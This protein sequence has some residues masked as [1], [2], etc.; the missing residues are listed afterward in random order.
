HGSGEAN[1]LDLRH[2]AEF[3]GGQALVLSPVL[4]L[5]LIYRAARWRDWKQDERHIL[6]MICFLA[7]FA[8]FLEKALFAKIQLNWALPAYLSVL[9]L[10]AAY[11]VEQRRRWLLIAAT[12]LP[13]MAL[14]AAIKWPVQM[15]LTGKNN[16]HNRLYGPEVAAREI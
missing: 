7:P 1:G 12:V 11:I 9:P 16:P 13:A 14:T 15:G 4:A 3:L 5:L 6:L 2:F 10:L 8:L